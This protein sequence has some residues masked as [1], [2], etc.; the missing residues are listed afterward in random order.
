MR[1]LLALFASLLMCG[2]AVAG[3][4]WT[5]YWSTEPQPCQDGGGKPAVSAYYPTCSVVE[6]TLSICR[7]MYRDG[8]PFAKG[9]PII[10]KGYQFTH[11]V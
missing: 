1:Y 8:S 5:I 9:K 2:T 7:S 4:L 6:G 10:V 11:L 3:D